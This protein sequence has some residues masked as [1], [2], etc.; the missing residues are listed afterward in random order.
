MS[1]TLDATGAYRLLALRRSYD[2]LLAALA[3][4]E[5]AL[6]CCPHGVIPPV[7]GGALALARPR[8]EAGRQALEAV[9][10]EAERALVPE[11]RDI[12]PIRPTT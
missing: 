5:R 2:D 12:L 8:L 11:A 3:Q 10:L 7:V 9:T 6:A 1:N 4:A